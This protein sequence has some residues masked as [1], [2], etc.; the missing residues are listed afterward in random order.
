MNFQSRRHRRAHFRVVAAWCLLALVSTTAAGADQTSTTSSA[1][2]NDPIEPSPAAAEMLKSMREKGILTDDEYEDLYRRQARYEAKER[3]ANSVPG[4]MQNW[5][6]GGDMRIRAERIDYGGFS[7][8]D[9]PLV[10]GD[11]NVDARNNKAIDKRNRF[12]FRYRFGAEKLLGEGFTAGFRIASADRI[13]DFGGNTGRDFANFGRD[14]DGDP[15]SG[16]V[17]FGR[18]FS[19]KS[20]G[21]DRV[22]VGW[23]PEFAPALHLAM[24]KVANPFVTT[25]FSGDVFMWDHDIN[26]EGFAAD[27]RFEVI[28]ERL[29]VTAA[30]GA[31]LIDE[32]GDVTVDNASETAPSIVEPDLDNEDP[33]MFAYQLG[34]HAQPLDWL[35][36][37][38]RASYYDL[39]KLGARFSA[40][41]MDY[42]NGGE[43]VH[44]NPI[45]NLFIAPGADYYETGKARG[46][47]REFVGDLF[48]SVVPFENRFGEMFKVT[49]FFQWMTILNA[50]HQD[51]G[52]VLGVDIGTPDILKLSI[53]SAKIERNATVSIFTDSDFFDG[54]TNAR[55]W[56]VSLERRLT[57]FMKL[58][59]TYL[60]SRQAEEECAASSHGL[61]GAFCEFA[62]DSRLRAFRKTSSDRERW[63]L[64]LTV[65]F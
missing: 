27:Y 35:E 65:D 4:W 6:V 21:L 43:A 44:H 9:E 50:A 60:N 14:L 30:F 63:Q 31:F 10:V 64:D 3:D 45:Y 25:R 15:R 46:E 36:L 32:I 28:P 37:G 20:I 58:R 47:L 53:I 5:T 7:D 56:G 11:D 2:A 40:A 12:R 59:G 34:I 62:N 55:G 38:G 22:Y 42:G 29:D 49:P 24:G 16:N 8:T 13:T 54:V 19:T 17:T 52:W 57:K 1:A 39:Q 61:P 18:Y 26:P 23:R 48:F 51:K 41:L 33:Y